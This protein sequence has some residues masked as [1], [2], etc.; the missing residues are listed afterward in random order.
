[1]KALIAD[2]A[3]AVLDMSA[4]ELVDEIAVLHLI[5]L[6][7]LPQHLKA[8]LVL[9]TKILDWFL[10]PDRV[11][12]LQELLGVFRDGRGLSGLSE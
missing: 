2:V 12:R 7:P 1:M 10:T 3:G 11:D 8:S 5:R 9:A 4:A 6:G